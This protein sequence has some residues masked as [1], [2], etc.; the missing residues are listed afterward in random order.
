MSRIRRLVNTAEIAARG[1]VE[2][3]L[4]FWRME[5]IERLQ[6]Y[7]LRAIIRHAYQA[8]PFYRQAMD[9]RA[10]RPND[11]RAVEDLAKLPLID[12]ITV[13]RDIEAFLS[14]RHRDSSRQAFYSAGS[15]TGIR[16]LTYWDNTSILRNLAHHRR[17]KVVL[18]DLLGKASG[19]S[20]LHIS[21]P[22]TSGLQL[23]GFWQASALIPRGPVQ[24]H[25]LSVEQP[26][27]VVAERINDLRPEVVSSY[28]SYAEQFFRYLADRHT[29]IAVP[30]LWI[31]G[32]DMLSASGRELIE[33][34]YG[35][36]TY[37]E[38]NTTETGPLG[39]QCE[40]RQGFHLNVDLCALRLVDVDGQTIEAGESGEVIISNLRN[41]ATVLLNYRLGDRAVLAQESCPCGRSLP[42]LE[43]LEGRSSE[44]LYLGDGRT[45]S[46]L[47]LEALCRNGLKP[48]LQIQIVQ[49]ARGQLKWRIVLSSNA[50]REAVRRG[51]LERCRTVLGDDTQVE[52]EFAE[53]IPIPPHG[54]FPRVVSHVPAPDIPDSITQGEE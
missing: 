10:L 51:L 39:F 44:T 41:R 23:Q 34:T 25:A 11:F 42:L 24:H 30:R 2:R 50:D 40:R 33:K 32:S 38:Y 28:G 46:G 53:E 49:P 36:P 4:P 48:A 9:E 13:Q 18:N 52:V 1:R 43:S 7:R 20:H 19:H 26:F 17:N 15:T 31:Y 8:V 16:R 6:G 37:S 12:G 3:T 27:E 29:N 14:T 54:K 35:C 45:V 22:H 47:T 21:P 5:W